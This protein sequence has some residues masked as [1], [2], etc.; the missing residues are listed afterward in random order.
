[1]SVSKGDAARPGDTHV[2]HGD[3]AVVG[4]GK[5][6]IGTGWVVAVELVRA[7]AT[8]VLVVAL[9]RVEDAASIA[10][11][12]LGRTARVERWRPRQRQRRRQRLWTDTPAHNR[13]R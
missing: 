3:A 10:A 11:P 12:E 13:E 8:V 5:L 4:A 7:V 2:G 1:M 9:P 6:A